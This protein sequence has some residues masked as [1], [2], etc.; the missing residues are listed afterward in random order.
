[1]N[2]DDVDVITGHCGDRIRRTVSESDVSTHVTA[3]ESLNENSLFEDFS[4][5][6]DVTAVDDEDVVRGTA[7][8]EE[9]VAGLIARGSCAHV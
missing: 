8:F 1:M 6:T 7:L 5:D 2:N 9:D 4:L 3:P